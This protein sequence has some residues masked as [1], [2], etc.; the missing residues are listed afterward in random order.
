M[1]YGSSY[2][3]Y[4]RKY[5]SRKYKRTYRKRKAQ[6]RSTQR[7]FIAKRAL[8][9]SDTR[10]GRINPDC[11]FA[12]LRYFATYTTGAPGL[13]IDRFY[14]GNSIYDPDAQT[15]GGQPSGYSL[16]DTQ[17]QRYQ[18]LGSKIKV[19]WSSMSDNING[20]FFVVPRRDTGAMIEAPEQ[21]YAVNGPIGVQSGATATGTL[22]KYMGTAKM[23]GYTGLDQME[24]TMS[25][26]GTNPTRQWYWGVAFQS[27]TPAATGFYRYSVTIDYYCKFLERK[28]YENI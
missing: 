10:A 2:K 28:S 17:Y 8:V 15:G 16:Y 18:V 26:F 7:S 24:I 3:R 1:P 20:Q 14:R 23:L 13:D 21:K 6:G 4:G 27:F 12:T 5:A 19:E 22:S 9:P 11:A 25:D